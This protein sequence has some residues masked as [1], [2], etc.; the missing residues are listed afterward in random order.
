MKGGH[1]RAPWPIAYE[2]A[3][4]YM[5]NGARVASV[6][7]ISTFAR[8]TMHTNAPHQTRRLGTADICMKITSSNVCTNITASNMCMG[9]TAKEGKEGTKGPHGHFAYEYVCVYAHIYTYIVGALPI[10]SHRCQDGRRSSRESP[11]SPGRLAILYRS[12]PD[13]TV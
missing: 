3:Y 11:P 7:R 12:S 5:R 13:S 10:S 6:A 9:G 2:Y 4:I 8:Q 1:H